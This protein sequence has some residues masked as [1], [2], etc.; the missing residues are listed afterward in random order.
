MTSNALPRVF[1][2]LRQSQLPLNTPVPEI[3]AVSEQFAG[4]FPPAEG[5]AVA[6]TERDGPKGEWLTPETP[7]PNAALLY[8][9]GGG[10][11]FGSPRSYRHLTTRLA[12]ATG[13]T[14]LALD[15]RLAPENPYPAAVE[16]AVRAYAHLL[17]MG[18][19]A[20][21]IAVAGDSAGGG[22]AVALLLASK[23]DG[24]P[25]PGYAVLFSPWLDL[26]CTGDSV[27]E[28]A[29][30][31]PLIRPEDLTRFARLYLGENL[32]ESPLASP[33]YG[34]LGGLPEMAVYV[35]TEEVLFDDAE[36]FVAKARRM[37]ASVA[38]SVRERM[39]HI[40]PFFAPML[41]EAVETIA[42]VGQSVRSKVAPAG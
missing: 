21:G 31:D 35:G 11:A 22:L 38:Y 6:V 36:R 34:D 30:R 5:V 20:G 1:D 29:G 4:F 39:P 32:P 9:H 33:L 12:A 41:P 40:W 2:M 25:M 18:I 13:L 3:R 8:L 42:E 10:Y 26:A 23:R 14:T 37:G 24:L 28:R 15:Y 19:P 17:E 16:D 27:R 7:V